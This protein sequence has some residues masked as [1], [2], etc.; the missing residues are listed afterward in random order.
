MLLG[1]NERELKDNAL[2]GSEDKNYTQV[3]VALKWTCINLSILKIYYAFLKYTATF[4]EKTPTSNVS[5]LNQTFFLLNCVKKYSRLF[6]VYFQSKHNDK[7][8][9]LKYLILIA[10][11]CWIKLRT[12]RLF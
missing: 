1:K 2:N 10:A 9:V 7:L 5:K 12:S 3:E 6:N 11:V 4:L 8:S